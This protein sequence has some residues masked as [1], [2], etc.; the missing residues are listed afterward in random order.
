[1]SLEAR[2]GDRSA[3]RAVARQDRTATGRALAGRLRSE[4]VPDES[5]D[6]PPVDLIQPVGVMVL[7]QLACLLVVTVV[8]HGAAAIVDRRST[9][10][11]LLFVMVGLLLAPLAFALVQAVYHGV[12]AY[13]SR[14]RR[15]G[16]A[17]CALAVLLLGLPIC[18]IS[19]VVIL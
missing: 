18:W 11:D 5:P 17:L 3:R 6:D 1:M 9:G 13:R 16:H 19:R 7:G 4:S 2:T 15:K 12:R 10:Y 14:A 8:C